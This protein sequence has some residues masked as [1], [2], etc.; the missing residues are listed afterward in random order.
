MEFSSS[1]SV[2]DQAGM[3]PSGSVSCPESA[4]R[5]SISQLQ[6][7]SNCCVWAA[8]RVRQGSGRL[9]QKKVKKSPSKEEEWEK[10]LVPKGERGS[11]EP[12]R[13]FCTTDSKSRSVHV[14]LTQVKHC[15]FRWGQEPNSFLCTDGGHQK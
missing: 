13:L 7:R 14:S 12:W 5:T 1:V 8:F 10:C 6:G 3:L 9:G 2:R 11:Y 4:Y 15:S